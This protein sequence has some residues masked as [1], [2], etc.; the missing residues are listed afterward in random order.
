MNDMKHERFI[1]VAEH[2]MDMLIRNFQ[3][4]G[5]CAAKASYEYTEEEVERIFAELDHQIRLLRDR[6]NGKK[7]FS[8]QPD[9]EERSEV[10]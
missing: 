4:L 6:F 1:K 3:K 10:K 5:D 8:L 7:T 9:A 2:R